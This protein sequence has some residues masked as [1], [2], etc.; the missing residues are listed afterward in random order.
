MIL[1]VT[2]AKYFQGHKVKLVFNNGREGVADLSGSLDGPIF[3]RL[4]DEQYFAQLKLDH[5][6]DTISWPNGADVAPEYL[7]FL[8]FQEDPELQEQFRT[9]GYTVERL[10]H[11]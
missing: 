4:K 11:H 10:A 7:Y 6:L 1:H 9:W 8:A 3:E 2:E 5:E